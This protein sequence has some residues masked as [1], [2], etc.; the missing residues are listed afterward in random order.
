[1][2]QPQKSPPAPQQQVNYNR[3]TMKFERT[4]KYHVNRSS[5]SAAQRRAIEEHQQRMRERDGWEY[6]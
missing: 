4:R 6:R 5:I 2:N 1:M 3:N